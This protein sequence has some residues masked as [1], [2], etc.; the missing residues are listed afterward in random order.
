MV[1]MPI[2]TT[3]I[4]TVFMWDFASMAIWKYQLLVPS[5]SFFLIFSTD[6]WGDSFSNRPW[7]TQ[8]SKMFSTSNGDCF[9]LTLLDSYFHLLL[10]TAVLADTYSTRARKAADWTFVFL[11]LL[12]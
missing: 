10:D 8:L 3:C 5:L 12:H 1:I 6:N 2:F 9:C 7:A 4:P 11:R